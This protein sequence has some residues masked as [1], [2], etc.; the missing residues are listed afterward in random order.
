MK[1]SAFHHPKI[2][3]LSVAIGLPRYA[4]VGIL[5]CLWEFTK[6]YA[7]NGS[8]ERW[9]AAHIAAQLDWD[10]DPDHLIDALVESGWIDRHPQMGL[11][12]HDW[13]D[14]SEDAVHL[15]LARDR[16]LFADGSIPKTGRLDKGSRESIESDLKLVKEQWD[17]AHGCAHERTDAHGI[18]H[19]RMDAHG[20]AQM[21]TSERTSERTIERTRERTA[22]PCHA[23]PCPPPPLVERTEC[24]QDDEGGG[25]GLFASKDELR[26]WWNQVARKKCNPNLPPCEPDDDDLESFN[27]FVERWPDF[28]SSVEAAIASRRSDLKLGLTL[29]WICRSEDNAK[30]LI[31]HEF[32]DASKAHALERS[33]PD[34]QP[35]KS[36]EPD[37]SSS[38]WLDELDKREQIR[39]GP[40]KDAG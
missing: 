32:S 2:R 15:K 4:C 30:R 12:V 6:Q 7:T 27:K 33:D 14:H 38:P 17:S 31:N 29:T 13:F 21:R 18:A 37:Y 1:S 23:M 8:L 35:S 10:K 25:D 26:D 3:L 34:R 36:A 28:K 5:E 39:I 16:H 22:L 24:A 20:C 40:D 11:M 19:E 9:G